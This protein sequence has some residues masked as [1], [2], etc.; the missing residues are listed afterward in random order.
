MGIC[1]FIQA[2]TYTYSFL[3]LG[4]SMSL[5]VFPALQ[6]SSRG[7]LGPDLLYEISSFSILR[8]A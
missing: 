2:Y 7:R 5:L 3:D 8:F 6:A 4:W 1:I